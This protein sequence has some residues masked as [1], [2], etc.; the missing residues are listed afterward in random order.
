MKFL[1]Q[2]RLIIIYFQENNNFVALYV[3]ISYTWDDKTRAGC[4]PTQTEFIL[5]ARNAK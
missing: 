5:Q 3:L 2:N 1:E 4:H